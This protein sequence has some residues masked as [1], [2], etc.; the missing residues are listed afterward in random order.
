MRHET[1]R[2][3]AIQMFSNTPSILEFMQGLHLLQPHLFLS[4]ITKMIYP[5][6]LIVSS[7]PMESALRGQA[8]RLTVICLH[9]EQTAIVIARTAT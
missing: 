9:L 3:N 6:H 1:H 8:V 2:F 7:L 5:L 4:I